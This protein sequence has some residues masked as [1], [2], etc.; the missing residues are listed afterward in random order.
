MKAQIEIMGLIVIVI[1]ITI[2]MFFYVALKQPAPEKS[3]LQVYSNEKL[4][5]D[6]LITYLEMT[7]PSCGVSMRQ[8]V[9]DCV[10]YNISTISFYDCADPDSCFIVNESIHSILERTLDPWSF[11]YE[12]RFSYTIND[13]RTTLIHRNTGCTDYTP[14]DSPGIQGLPK[15]QDAVPE[16]QLDICG[17]SP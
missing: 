2:G 13:D 12:F 10:R 15:I 14:R 7:E 11:N 1:L 17:I 5:G 6:F 16:L 4:A 8:L 9:I 3:L